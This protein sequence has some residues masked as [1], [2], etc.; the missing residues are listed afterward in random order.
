MR[1]RDGANGILASHESLRLEGV[2]LLSDGFRPNPRAQSIDTDHA[3]PGAILAG[4]DR[5]WRPRRGF[6]L[7]IVINHIKT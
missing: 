2:P 4:V 7:M 5:L 6:I 1:S 3:D